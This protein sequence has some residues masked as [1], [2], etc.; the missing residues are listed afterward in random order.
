METETEAGTDVVCETHLGMALGINTVMGSD[1]DIDL[2]IDMNL[3][4]GKGIKLAITS[5][6][7]LEKRTI[8]TSKDITLYL[9]FGRGVSHPQH[10]TFW[11]LEEALEHRPSCW[12]LKGAL[13]QL[14]LYWPL[15]GAL[16]PT[17]LAEKALKL[18][19]AF[20]L[21]SKLQAI[22]LE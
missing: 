11:P 9:K 17:Q 21:S 10:G 4:S 7:N 22:L 18:F 3:D 14:P 8:K 16:E 5:S 2:G 12:P 13:E 15:K 1:I 6:L 20:Q 19:Q